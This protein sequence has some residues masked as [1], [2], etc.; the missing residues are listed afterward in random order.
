MMIG[1]KSW[2]IRIKIDTGKKFKINIPVPV[3]VLTECFYS[4]EGFML[5][6]DFILPRLMAR[7]TYDQVFGSR[8]GFYKTVQTVTELFEALQE[9]GGFSLVDI[10]SKDAKVS[11]QFI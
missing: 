2:L 8:F 11:V 10:D 9:C 3:Y 6:L 4:L 7:K 5:I 1:E